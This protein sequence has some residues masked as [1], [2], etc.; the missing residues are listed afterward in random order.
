MN[1][2]SFTVLACLWSITFYLVSCVVDETEAEFSDQEV[3]SSTITAAAVF[4]ETI[5]E[6]V[7]EAQ[8]ITNQLSSTYDDLLTITAD[9]LTIDQ[10]KAKL[11]KIQKKRKQ[12]N[13][14]F[15]R[16][17]SI[18]DEIAEYERR[19]QSS[20]KDPT[21]YVQA[22]L[23]EIHQIYEKSN[24]RIDFQRIEDLITDLRQ[25]IEE[26]KQEQNKPA[27]LPQTTTDEQSDTASENTTSRKSQPAN[28][29]AQKEP[30]DEESSKQAKPAKKSSTQKSESTKEATP[31]QEKP[32]NESTQQKQAS[33]PPRE[34]QSE[35]AKTNDKGKTK[36]G[37]IE[38]NDEENVESN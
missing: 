36:E 11:E 33:N 34:E 4:P 35:S 23:N 24:E 38:N 29:S 17:S 26:L 7:K 8:G 15:Q 16:L 3:V 9:S 21:K 28:E 18:R 19:A 6:L 22:G 12:M 14:N 2:K 27:P 32:A 37:E 10:A 5:E 1:L 13:T 30:T 20:G 31:Q 25:R